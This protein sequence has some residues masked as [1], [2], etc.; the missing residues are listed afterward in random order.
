MPRTRHSASSASVD[1]N[2][3][4]AGEGEG[5][6]AP[7][8]HRPG[9]FLQVSQ[10]AA[11]FLESRHAFTAHFPRYLARGPPDCKNVVPS[12]LWK[13]VEYNADSP[14][15]R[16][17]MC[18]A[19]DRI[20]SPKKQRTGY[21]DT[22]VDLGASAPLQ[23]TKNV[24][25]AFNDVAEVLS[26]AGEVVRIAL[27]V[28]EDNPIVEK[29]SAT[30]KVNPSPKGVNELFVSSPDV[31]FGAEVRVPAPYG[32][33]T[34]V[35]CT[36]NGR[37]PV[38][39]WDQLHKH[40]STSFGRAH[41]AD[42]AL[43]GTAHWSK[44]HVCLNGDEQMGGKWADQANSYLVQLVL[45]KVKDSPPVEHR[46]EEFQEE[47]TG[48]K[49]ILLPSVV[50]QF[51]QSEGP[52]IRASAQAA[53]H[54]C[55]FCQT[56][57][58][59]RPA[60][61]W[62]MIDGTPVGDVSTPMIDEVL[63]VQRQAAA[64]LGVD[65]VAVDPDS[66]VR[67]VA[68]VNTAFSGKNVNDGD[69]KN[70]RQSQLAAL[71]FW[72]IYRGINACSYKMFATL[73]QLMSGASTH[74]EPPKQT[75]RKRALN[76]WTRTQAPRM[77]VQ[78]GVAEYCEELMS[79]INATSK[80]N[81]KKE[82]RTSHVKA[83]FILTALSCD[84]AKR[85]GFNAHEVVR[86]IT[87]S[88][89]FLSYLRDEVRVN[90]SELARLFLKKPEPG[91]TL[92]KMVKRWYVDG[93]DRNVGLWEA[94]EISGQPDLLIE[95]LYMA[96]AEW[97]DASFR[98]VVTHE[99][100][101]GATSVLEL[102]ADALVAIGVE[103]LSSHY[104]ARIN[105]KHC[106]DIPW[107]MMYLISDLSHE[108][109]EEIEVRQK[110]DLPD[111][112]K[113]AYMPYITSHYAGVVFVAMDADE[114]TADAARRHLG[115]LGL[116]PAFDPTSTSGMGFS[117]IY[118][119]QE[120]PDI[121]AV[122]YDEAR[123]RCRSNMG[124]ERPKWATKT[125]AGF[126]KLAAQYPANEEIF[127]QHFH[128]A[129]AK[130]GHRVPR[131]TAFRCD[132]IS[133]LSDLERMLD[134]KIFPAQSVVCV[135][136]G[137]MPREVPT[138]TFNVATLGK[139]GYF[140]ND[141]V[142]FPLYAVPVP[143]KKTGKELEFVWIY[144]VYSQD[145]TG[146]PTVFVTI[147]SMRIVQLDNIKKD[148]HNMLVSMLL[149]PSMV[150]PY[151][152]VRGAPG[153]A[154]MSRACAGGRFANLPALIRS[155]GSRSV[156]KFTMSTSSQIDDVFR[157]ILEESNHDVAWA[158]MAHGVSVAASYFSKALGLRGYEYPDLHYI[159]GE[160]LTAFLQHAR[161]QVETEA[162]IQ[163]DEE[164]DKRY[165]ALLYK[166]ERAK[167]EAIASLSKAGDDVRALQMQVMPGFEKN[168][169]NQVCVDTML[170]KLGEVSEAANAYD[171]VSA[172]GADPTSAPSA[173]QLISGLDMLPLGNGDSSA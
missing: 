67:V 158:E 23:S 138:Y 6:P 128:A 168:E 97:I 105:P 96:V 35:P 42:F 76:S 84:P 161:L 114:A 160:K 10:S 137:I 144:F 89:E 108:S 47:V 5:P 37:N 72:A 109:C 115:A 17:A 104:C 8:Q 155:L 127:A 87:R 39:T 86:M 30:W 49:S 162:I 149:D 146:S 157:S 74:K 169:V 122:M 98:E 70:L 59:I 111:V 40:P 34:F 163:R 18:D 3:G 88:A 170:A 36:F 82:K 12:A 140:I 48:V 102:I 4:N 25:T 116:V 20:P 46:G 110:V 57:G 103:G 69:A 145:S 95:G 13:H 68:L 143:F 148:P 130:K 29:M 156:S 126:K 166:K 16:K 31:D 147:H 22:L 142:E 172:A 61:K 123:I 9:R 38:A 80:I 125:A 171:I 27:D 92:E 24:V 77:L 121:M 93:P 107:L 90:D 11:K 19:L 26:T 33:G 135:P 136:D 118:E 112:V 151:E 167:H 152:G 71:V 106:P 78:G 56:V 32:D 119:G 15:K 159:W 41:A 81:P 50:S 7:D 124:F 173:G 43:K 120:L 101:A 129:H 75:W 62:T 154:L 21:A 117:A 99:T 58:V 2:G 85:V 44:I 139:I 79:V 165:S 113:R 14:S 83:S 45:V 1:S 164:H 94:F 132:K 53:G 66:A 28:G 51:M 141:G 65:N 60:E 54:V 100:L 150:R 64:S 153:G 131:F 133:V 91:E 63:R 55:M 73:L 134:A 52:I